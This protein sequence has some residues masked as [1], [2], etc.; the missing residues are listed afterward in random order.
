MDSS[1]LAVMGLSSVT[2]APLLCFEHPKN[3]RKKQSDKQRA[4]VG[5]LTVVP[6][7]QYNLGLQTYTDTQARSVFYLKRRTFLWPALPAVIQPCR[8][9]VGMPQPLLHLGNVRVMSEC[10]GCSRGTQSMHAEAVHIGVDAY[11]S[12]VVPDN[13]L[14]H[15]RWVQMLG[16]GFADVVLHRPKECTVE[17]VLVLCLIQILGD[18]SLRFEVHWDVAHLVAFAVHAKVEHAFALLEIAHAQLA[19]FLPVQAVIEQRGED[20]TVTFAFKRVC[21]RCFEEHARLLVAER[22]REAF[23]G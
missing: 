10:I 17:I 11:H 15:G 6:C 18:E 20:G 19:E 8:G 2:G 3:N 9:N 1:R 12:A 23:I 21:W 4:C 13:L 14:I 5:R 22:R 16:E 7:E